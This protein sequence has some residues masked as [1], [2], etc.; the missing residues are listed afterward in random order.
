MT[1]QTKT[2]N[3]FTVFHDAELAL[4]L[5]MQLQTQWNVGMIG[6][7]GLDYASVIAVIGLYE[8]TGSGQRERLA[9]IQAL[10][11]GCLQGW[12][13]SR[14]SQT[15]EKP[16]GFNRLAINERKSRRC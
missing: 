6:A 3:D 4:V 1:N 14:D 15:K 16:R 13:D 12:A 5:F 7:I 10:E 9:E 11:T 8:K 2:A